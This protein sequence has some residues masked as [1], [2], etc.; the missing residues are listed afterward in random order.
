MRVFVTGGTGFVGRA[1]VDRLLER[2][3]EVTLLARHPGKAVR[4]DPRVHV[5]QGD[6]S[7]PESLLMALNRRPHDAVIHLVGIIREN[8]RKGITFDRIHVQGT[9]NMVEAA[10]KAGI[11]RFLHMSANGAKPEGT[12]YQTTKWQAERLVKES[13]LNWTIFRP[14]L[15]T[16]P[17]PG[18]DLQMAQMVRR[19]PVVP[20]FGKGD[21]KVA[22]IALTDVTTAFANALD[23]PG[24]V[25]ETFC[26]CGPEEFTFKEYLQRLEGVLGKHRP[27]M[28]VP[29]GLML[30]AAGA[31]GRFSAFPATR[32]Q[33]TMLFEGNTCS[34]SGDTAC[35]DYQEALG[36]PRVHTWEEEVRRFLR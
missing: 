34:T 27:L 28:P 21:F 36:M 32:D 17:G 7:D 3:H 30:T 26:L 33:L 11:H 15:I 10:R 23:H 6:V 4:N 31:L 16:G 2:G 19:S 12:A 25:G 24:T 14:S 8:R 29:Q 22:P 9:R 18:F 20:V 1:M 5:A 35:H 13:G